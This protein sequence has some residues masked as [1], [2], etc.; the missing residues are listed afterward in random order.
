MIDLLRVQN[1]WQSILS[2]GIEAQRAVP[3]MDGFYYGLNEGKPA[4]LI[5]S[6]QRLRLAGSNSV[7]EVS[8][9]ARDIDTKVVSLIS[10]TDPNYLDL[11]VRSMTELFALS[12]KSQGTQA[13][14]ESFQNA[15]AKMQRL[16]GLRNKLI[17]QEMYRG[18]FAELCV[19]Q[20]VI[21]AKIGIDHAIDSWTGPGGSAQDF[22]SEEGWAVE[23]K[24]IRRGDLNVSISS[25]H[26]LD[27]A[28]YAAF[29]LLA[30]TLVESSAGKTVAEKYFEISQLT[31]TE[32]AA[33]QLVSKI[34]TVGTLAEMQ[35]NETRLLVEKTNAY[36][37]TLD[38]PVIHKAMLPMGISGVK[39]S[40]NLRGLSGGV[41][42]DCY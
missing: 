31:E 11:F 35:A 12:S 16:F 40:L 26:Q 6:H 30:V 13:K 42:V 29:E 10:L 23:V 20:S 39:Y 38:S 28:G 17:T 15:F 5:I 8:Y 24:S 37:I 22:V 36:P 32:F 21:A 14:L 1:T 9:R 41:N 4:V 33:E 25:E 18:L 3:G 34:E 2:H 7:V 19:L 27:A